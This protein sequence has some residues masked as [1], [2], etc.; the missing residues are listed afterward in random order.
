MARS[1]W[2]RYVVIRPG[3]SPSSADLQ[4]FLAQK[5]PDYMV[6]ATYVFLDALPLT[7]NGKVNRQALPEP[8]EVARSAEQD[9]SLRETGLEQ[10]RELVSG[11]LG[12]T[13]LDP[14][15]SLLEYGATSIDV[16]RIVNRLD[17]TL[18]Y[19]P[20]IGDLYRD[21]TIAGLTR[22]YQRHLDE[23]RPAA[24]QRHTP[25]PETDANVHRAHRP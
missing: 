1:G 22:S 19:R 9:R 17:E 13:K 24:P 3:S 18:G 7:P 6:P 10:M 15:V 8:P 2:L 21:L 25:A 11:V 14:E 23:N 5:L 20:R 16:I 4:A 12:Q